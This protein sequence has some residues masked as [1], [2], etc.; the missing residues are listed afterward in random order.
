MNRTKGQHR[1]FAR[2]RDD[3]RAAGRGLVDR[4]DARS[5]GGDRG[6]RGRRDTYAA[7]A[8]VGGRDSVPVTRRRTAY[9]QCRDRSGEI[10]HEDIAD[11]VIVGADTVAA[12][13]VDVRETVD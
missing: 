9:V 8:V 13:G 1:S 11:S 6:A 2:G 10:V 5:A 12:S 7:G 3:E 4:H